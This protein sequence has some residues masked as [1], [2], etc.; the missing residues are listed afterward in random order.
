MPRQLN[1]QE[2]WRFL[3]PSPGP[4]PGLRHSHSSGLLM[5]FSLHLSL[6]PGELLGHAA[7]AVS[8]RA[9]ACLCRLGSFAHHKQPAQ[10]FVCSCLHK[11]DRTCCTCSRRFSSKACSR[12]IFPGMQCPKICPQ[13]LL[14]CPMNC[15]NTDH[16][17]LH[18][19]DS[20]ARH[21]STC[22]C[23]C[24]PTAHQASQDTV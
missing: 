10:A 13:A 24:H 3:P 1:P 7:I 19:P 11:V 21:V 22:E 18:T 6:G 9:Q 15:S 5:H 23:S 17:P 16:P 4:Q 20:R 12:L 14:A 8:D 2:F